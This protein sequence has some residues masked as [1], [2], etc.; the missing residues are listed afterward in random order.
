MSKL[1]RCPFCGGE[2][3]LYS[4]YSKRSRF[5]KA[6]CSLCGSGSR[7]YS[8][9]NTDFDSEDFWEQYAA[10]QAVE[11][12]NRRYLCAECESMDCKFNHGGECRFALVHERKPRITDDD[13]C[14]DYDY[15]EGG[16]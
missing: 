5:I 8:C 3:E 9:D 15:R 14:T 2:A 10:Q 1:K 6:Q 7:I 12:W 16:Y 13:G 11:A 4:F